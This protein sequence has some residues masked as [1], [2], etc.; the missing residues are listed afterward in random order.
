MSTI[1]SRFAM[2]LA[3]I[4]ALLALS[5]APAL[6]DDVD[7]PHETDPD[8]WGQVDVF[9]FNGS[10]KD[11]RLC[12]STGADCSFEDT[13]FAQLRYQLFGFKLPGDS[14]CTLTGSIVSQHG[15]LEMDE[16]DCL[17]M[18]TA[19]MC[20]HHD[21]GEI[22]VRVPVELGADNRIFGHLVLDP[23][24]VEGPTV[25][26]Y[27]PRGIAFGDPDDNIFTAFNY[28]SEAEYHHNYISADFDEMWDAEELIIGASDDEGECGWP[29]LS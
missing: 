12:T 16:S 29:E 7:F 23:T 5:A 8:L 24:E 28:N 11:V 22:W 9:D 1:R 15:T 14:N 25:P 26:T 10:L 18:S 20:Q 2:L 27:H 3:G 6:A 13:A 17:G 19:E 21:T 4:L